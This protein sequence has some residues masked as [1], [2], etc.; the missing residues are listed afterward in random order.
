MDTHT[1]T[2]PQF[3]IRYLSSTRVVFLSMLVFLSTLS[4]WYHNVVFSVKKTIGTLLIRR[5]AT[6]NIYGHGT[7]ARGWALH[8]PKSLFYVWILPLWTSGKR[9]Q[10]SE[11]QK[12]MKHIE[13]Y[14]LLIWENLCLLGRYTMLEVYIIH[15][16]DGVCCSIWSD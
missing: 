11:N 7:S 9:P 15:W 1:H 4:I 10:Y 16:L 2:H 5:G 12:S 8:F 3:S 13:T 14:K 6:W